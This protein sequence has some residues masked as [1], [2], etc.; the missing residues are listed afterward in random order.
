ML[1]FG[2]RCLHPYHFFDTGLKTDKGKVLYLIDRQGAKSVSIDNARRSGF[3]VT[4]QLDNFIEV[5][6]GVCVSCRINRSRVWAF[7]CMAELCITA[8]PSYFVTLTYDPRHCPNKLVKNDLVLFNKRLRK[9]FGSFRFY[10]CG[11]YGDINGR[12][13]YHV[14]YF[15]LELDDLVFYKTSGNKKLFVSPKLSRCWGKGIC[16]VGEVDYPSCAYVAG[17][18]DKKFQ[19]KDC[20]TLMSRRPGIGLSVF[21]SACSPGEK[22]VLPTFKGGFKSSSAPRSAFPDYSSGKSFTDVDF[23]SVEGFDPEELDK[24]EWLHDYLLKHPLN[25]RL[26]K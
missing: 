6:C 15:G 9:E 23:L 4:H 16:A 18:V 11:E 1:Y 26:P 24:W 12:P 2:M 8:K 21:R 10:G 5:P 7:R 22:L 13:H 14:I 17:Y 25:R 20:F 19:Y 3:P